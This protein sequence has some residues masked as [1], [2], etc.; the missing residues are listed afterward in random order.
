VPDT[1]KEENS[2]RTV[3]VPT[4][5]GSCYIPG[6]IPG[7]AYRSSLLQVG[8]S[9]CFGSR[10]RE[11]QAEGNC[12]Y[13]VVSPHKRK[14]TTNTDCFSSGHTSFKSSVDSYRSL[15]QNSAKNGR[16]LNVTFQTRT[17]KGATNKMASASSERKDRQQRSGQ[18]FQVYTLFRTKRCTREQVFSSSATKPA[19]GKEGRPYIFPHLLP[20]RVEELQQTLLSKGR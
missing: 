16:V 12:R 2:G 1:L 14:V 6:S 3:P 15:F 8:H 17:L 19:P 11:T 9:H 5:K 13:R 20:Q 4:V 7:A 18:D 10:D